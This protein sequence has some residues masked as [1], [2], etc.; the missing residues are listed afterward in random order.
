MW[1]DRFMATAMDT[2]KRRI[3][4]RMV[5]TLPEDVLDVLRE[6]ED[7]SKVVELALRRY[8][9]VVPNEVAVWNA[10]RP[11]DRDELRRELNRLRADLTWPGR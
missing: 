4:K 11:D 10:E 7:M 5:F 3:R 1:Y 8:Y 9:G 6:E 2:K